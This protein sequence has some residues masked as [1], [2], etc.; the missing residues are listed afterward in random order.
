MI[1]KPSKQFGRVPKGTRLETIFDIE[2]DDLYHGVTKLHVL[3]YQ[4]TTMEKPVSI[5]GYDEIRSFFRE[6]RTFIGHHI[7]GY[8]MPTLLKLLGIE[9][10]P[11]GNFVDTLPLSWYLN[12]KRDKHGLESYGQEA[13]VPKPPIKDWK[14]LTREDYTFRCESDVRINMHV[15]KVLRAKLVALYT[16]SKPVSVT[17]DEYI[18]GVNF[19]SPEFSWVLPEDAVRLI[20]YMNFK[21]DC[22]FEQYKYKWR[23]DIPHCEALR[24]KLAKLEEEA[25]VSLVAVMPKIPVMKEHKRPKVWRKKDGELSSHA[26]NFEKARKEACQPEGVQSFETVKGY[27]DG[28]PKSHQQ[29]KDWLYSLGWEPCTWKFTKEKATGKDKQIPQ[30]R[31]EGELTDSVLL[32]VEK[33]PELSALEGLTV[34]SHRLGIAKAFLSKVDSEG[35][36]EAGATGLTNTFRLKHSKPCVNLPGVDKPYGRDIRACLIAP[37]GYVLC[38]SDMVSLEDTTKRHWMKPHDP[39]YVEEMSQPGYDPHLALAVF[40]GKVTKEDYDFYGQ[41]DTAEDDDPILKV[42]QNVTRFKELK[43]IRKAY[44]VVNYSAV[45]GIAAKGLSRSSGLPVAQ[46]EELLEAYWKKNFA[47]NKAVKKLKVQKMRDGSRW[48]LNP[49]SRFWYQL[50]S[51]KD[52][53]STLNQG[54]GVFCFDMELANIRAQ[55]VKVIGQFHDEHIDLVKIG[56]EEVHKKILMKANDM[57]NEQIRLNVDLGVDVQFG[58]AYSDIH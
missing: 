13:G 3:S 14:D 12:Y 25:L 43:G 5:Y 44:K 57:T 46:C 2:G 51:E 15:W 16:M 41:M 21:N 58:N 56:D 20:K 55:G 54:T 23:I 17:S 22:L 32:L 19:L 37:E 52:K 6:D 1:K 53:F 50:R 42:V 39:A 27:E 7:M 49:V 29:V 4:D 33:F 36:V 9:Y 11:R 48:L 40:S 47:V 24:D 28:N 26:V 8:D 18:E 31:K 10:E 45:Y 35:Y 38:G 34:V 30:V